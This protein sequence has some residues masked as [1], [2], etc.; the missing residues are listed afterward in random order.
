MYS[1]WPG[2][3]TLSWFVYIEKLTASIDTILTVSVS[4]STNKDRVI[5]PGQIL[6]LLLVSQYQQIK[7]E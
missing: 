2:A 6:H 5:A 4:I 1:I 3:I 7:T